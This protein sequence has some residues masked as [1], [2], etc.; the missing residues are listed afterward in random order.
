MLYGMHIKRMITCQEWKPVIC[1]RFLV[2]SGLSTCRQDR[3]SSPKCYNLSGKKIFTFS[4][5]DYH[6]WITETVE[7]K[8]W[9]YTVFLAVHR[10]TKIKDQHH[11]RHKGLCLSLLFILFWIQVSPSLTLIALWK[12]KIL[13]WHISLYKV[14]WG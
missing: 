12:L 6:K 9:R 2:C 10:G 7:R 13:V 14:E 8:T 3:S 11:G 4:N 5:T 1:Q